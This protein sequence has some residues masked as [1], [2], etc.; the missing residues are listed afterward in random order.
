[1]LGNYWEWRE[2]LGFFVVI[3]VVDYYLNDDVLGG[4]RFV[5]CG[6]YIFSR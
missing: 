3:L 5:I 2:N 4:E 6:N 1:M